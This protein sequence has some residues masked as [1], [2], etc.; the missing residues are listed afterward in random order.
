[1]S[2]AAP[3]SGRAGPWRVLAIGLLAAMAAAGCDEA[4][5]WLVVIARSDLAPSEEV[6]RIDVELV[7]VGVTTSTTVGRSASLREGLPIYE[8]RL[9]TLAGRRVRVTFFLDDEEIA[10]RDL[11]FDHMAD[12]TIAVVVPRLCVDVACD[13]GETCVLGQCAEPGCVDGDEPGCPEAICASD[14]ACAVADVPCAGG[15][16]AEGTCLAYGD[17]D[18]CADG[19]W[20]DPLSGCAPRRAAQDASAVDAG[21]ADPAYGDSGDT[22]SGDTDTGDTA[23]DPTDAGMPA[24]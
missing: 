19:E 22:D 23:A 15:A 1:M 16:C 8:R 17:D 10:V 13:E 4:D 7:G 21:D 14:D 11:V 9:A 5:P 24:I 6:D 12:R 3:A 18:A 20:C 2:D